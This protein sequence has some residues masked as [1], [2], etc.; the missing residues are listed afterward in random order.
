MICVPRP[1][2]IYCRQALGQLLIVHHIFEFKSLKPLGHGQYKN[3]IKYQTA[4]Q[5]RPK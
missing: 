5:T 3:L 1:N 4:D 2:R